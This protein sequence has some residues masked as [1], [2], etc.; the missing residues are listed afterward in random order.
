MMR[1]LKPSFLLLLFLACFSKISA[2]TASGK[3]T[4]LGPQVFASLIQGSVFAED[5]AGNSYAYTVVRGRPAHLIGFRLHPTKQVLDVELEGTDGSWDVEVSTDG[6]VYIAAANGVLFKHMPG[7][8]SVT[9]LGKVLPGE[10]VIWD[11]V[12]GKDGEIFGG[13]YPGA[14]VFRYHPKDGFKDVGQ[15]ALVKDEN[16][17]RS[18]TYHK[19]TGKIY[20][21]IASHSAL[22][23]LDP[24]TGAK[25]QLLADK[26]RDQEAIYH[27]NLVN[28]LKGG[29]RVFGWLTGPTERVT[30]IY[31]IKTK[32]FEEYMPTLDVKSVIK[33]PK[34][35]HVYYTAGGKL[36][37]LDYAAKKPQPK[38]LAH[39]GGETKTIRWGKDGQLYLLTG[40]KH[41]HVY[42][43]KTGKHITEKLEV[44]GQPIDIQSIGVGPDGLIWTGGYLAGGHATYNPE[45][46]ENVQYPGLDQTE[47]MANLGSSIYFGIYAKARLYAHDTKKPWD[48][49][50]GNPKFLG[51]IKGQDRPF[52][53]LGL[54]KQ[55]KV[56]FGTVPGYGILG[57]ALV[58]YDVAADKLET[59][60]GLIPDQSIISL[61]QAG[62][63][64]LGGTSIYGGLGGVP[65]Q[66][67][68]KIFG[69]DPVQKKKVFELIPVPGAMSVTGLAQVPGGNIWGFADG[70][71]IVFDPTKREVVSK[72]KFFTMNSNPTHI[73]RNAFLQVHPNGL[74]YVAVNGKLYSV[75]PANMK[76]TTIEDNVSLL[77]MDQKGRL[78]FRRMLD[79]W[80]Y[81]PATVV[82]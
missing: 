31:N 39:L 49:K 3:F 78:Y 62:E 67:E 79:L 50:Q 24:K 46:G 20:A 32:K 15:G 52:A 64:V 54:E 7:T 26:D 28:G 81:D 74:V 17:V 37:V 33:A 65:T 42:N 48:T 22:V 8:D 10:K 6:V 35:S 21:G 9:S 45:T 59:F 4:N 72:H 66:K 69:W 63:V 68:A 27:I 19:A 82:E 16:Y 2:Q 77:A 75:D 30:A 73:W 61:V 41:F 38:E 56:L 58:D 51:Q 43:P 12:A 57:G 13:T 34:G 47:G 60:E 1:S 23:E 80:R 55:N 29:D 11:L 70:D 18:V 36:F 5:A 53:V 40:S 71:L 76:V 14:R 25:K 44:P